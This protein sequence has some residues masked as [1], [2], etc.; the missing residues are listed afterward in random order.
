MTAGIAARWL[1]PRPTL[2][3]RLGVGLALLVMTTV[4]LALPTNLSPFPLPSRLASVGVGLA[5]AVSGMAIWER[6]PGNRLGPMLV[7]SG[8]LWILGRLQGAESPLIALLAN[9]ANSASQVGIFAALVTFPTGRIPSTIASVLVVYSLVFVTASN[10]F[11]STAVQVQRLTGRVNPLYLAMDPA[12]RGNLLA[13]LQLA[14]Y[15]GGAIGVGWLIARWIRASR[16]GRRSSLPIVLAAVA[17]IAV[18]VGTQMII[19]AGGLTDD[20]LYGLVTVQI[21]SFAL[22]PAAIAVSTL[23]DRMARAAVADLVVE[24]GD[25][26]TPARLRDALAGALGDPS[27]AIGFWSPRDADYVDATGSPVTLPEASSE[28]ALTRLERDGRPLAVIVHDPVLLDDPGLV[29]SVSAAVRLAVDNERLTAEVREQLANVRESR[30]RLVSAGDAE[31]RRMERDLHDGAQQRLVALSLALRRARTTAPG[32]A[33]DELASTLDDAAT[34]VREALAELRE[35]A[36]GIHPAVL[37]ETGLAGAIRALAERSSVP[38]TIAEVPEGRLP[39]S[40]ETAAY[41]FVSE[42]LANA[43]KHAPDASVTVRLHATDQDLSVEVADDG[44]GGARA[45]SGS[46]LIG[47]EDRLAALDGRLEIDSPPGRGTRLRAWI[48]FVPSVD[49]QPAAP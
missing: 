32:E 28:R 22:L 24:L 1:P 14:T 33:G 38:V 13:G 2:L 41:F 19:N 10:L 26:P 35:L 30:A 5:I 21:S 29:P 34:L 20:Q 49:P 12:V 27:L 48:P 8:G 46:G 40:V 17:L 16:P 31:R 6:R 3:L 9:L 37:S 23:R 36:R 44:P 18:A 15:L 42:G 7:L 4:A 45:G 43:A 25:V 39:S 11:A 47:L